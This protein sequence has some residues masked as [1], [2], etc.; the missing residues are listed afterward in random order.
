MEATKILPRVSRKIIDWT[1]LRLQ[2]KK[3]LFSLKAHNFIPIHLLKNQETVHFS[4][5]LLSY[6]GVGTWVILV[7]WKH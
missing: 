5:N 1:D 4:S 6:A 7:R 3:L 2:G